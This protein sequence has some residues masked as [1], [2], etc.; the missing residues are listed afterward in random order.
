[1]T[2]TNLSILIDT[3]GRAKAQEADIL[4]ELKKLKQALEDL[5]PGA[6]EG[7]L[8][9]LTVSESTR[10]TL[11]MEAVREKL[12]PQFMRAHTNIAEVRTLR[13]SARKGE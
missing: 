5:K 1:M 2:E 8:F 13:V 9:R 7:E 6:Y 12:T 3:F 10:E 4:K 11:D